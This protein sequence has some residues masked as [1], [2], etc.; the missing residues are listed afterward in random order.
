M[1]KK[2]EDGQGHEACG[3]HTPLP[4]KLGCT[5]TNNAVDLDLCILFDLAIDIDTLLQK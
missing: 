1:M 5:Q 4:A 2:V 3:G